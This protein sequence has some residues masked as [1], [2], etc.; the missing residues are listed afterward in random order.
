MKIALKKVSG[1][2]SCFMDSSDTSLSIKNLQIFFEIMNKKI[3]YQLESL[4]V[5]VFLNINVSQS[6]R[7]FIINE[8]LNI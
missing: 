7:T 2:P 6:Q 1:L 3:R 8:R 4:S 5:L